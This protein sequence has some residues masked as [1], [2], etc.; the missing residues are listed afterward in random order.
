MSPLSIDELK[1]RLNIPAVWRMLALPGKPGLSCVSPFRQE[2]RPSFSVYEDG[3]RFKDHATGEGGDVL[4]FIALA[5]GGASS[6]DALLWARQQCGEAAQLAAT[7]ETKPS[8]PA[9]PS[10]WPALRAGTAQEL[11]ALA[12][13][14]GYAV[15]T[16]REAQRLGL[17]AFADQWGRVAWCI[18]DSSGRI[19]EARR[20]DGKPWP[21]FGQMPERKCHAWGSKSWPVGLEAAASC[22]KLAL[23]EGGPDLLAALEIIQAEGKTE[24]VAVVAVLGA[25]AGRFCP[26]ALPYFRQKEVR[27]FPHADEAGMRGCKAWALALRDAGAAK[28]DAFDLAGILRKDGQPGKDLCDL[29]NASSEC[30]KQWPKF[31]GEVMP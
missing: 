3:R 19:C 13:L 29:L 31:N 9:K 25:A 22:S 11:A 30:L 8:L 24:S 23:V 14:R 28:L 26:E 4:D 16:V 12:V 27:I 1:E 21:A 15:E 7:Q 2:R 5:L 17:L 18:T 10:K 6:A 20:L